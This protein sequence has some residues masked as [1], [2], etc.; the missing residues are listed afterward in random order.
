MFSQKKKKK[1]KKKKLH[2]SF[3]STGSKNISTGF[4]SQQQQQRCE[5]D[6]HNYR[7]EIQQLLSKFENH[8]VKTERNVYSH[9]QSSVDVFFFPYFLSFFENLMPMFIKL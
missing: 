2:E 5:I 8:Q 6:L 4:K 3:I 1:K 7:S 9:L